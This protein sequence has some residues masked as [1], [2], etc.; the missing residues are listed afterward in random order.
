MLFN[1]KFSNSN[2]KNI[3]II[4]NKINNQ[5]RREKVAVLFSYKM[6]SKYLINKAGISFIK[7][8]VKNTS[9]WTNVRKL[10]QTLKFLYRIIF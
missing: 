8:S 9:W 7:K 10:L 4:F 1:I 3:F 5:N 2:N 6:N